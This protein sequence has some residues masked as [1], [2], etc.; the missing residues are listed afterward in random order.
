MISLGACKLLSRGLYLQYL[1]MTLRL[2]MSDWWLKE[3]TFLLFTYTCR[4]ERQE[5]R[6]DADPV[7][8]C[9]ALLVLSQVVTFALQPAPDLWK[10]TSSAALQRN[11]VLLVDLTD[12]LLGSSE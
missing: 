12:C 4:V 7:C 5:H 3:F 2:L 11:G 6:N 10:V 1:H 9:A 8:L